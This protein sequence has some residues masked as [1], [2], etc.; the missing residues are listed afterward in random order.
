[1]EKEVLRDKDTCYYLAKNLSKMLLD[2]GLITVKEYSMLMELNRKSFKPFL[3]E[4]FPQT[5]DNT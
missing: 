2:N 1:M 5:L 4:L 3:V